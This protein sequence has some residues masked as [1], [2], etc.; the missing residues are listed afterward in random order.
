MKAESERIELN[1]VEKLKDVFLSLSTFILHSS[2]S[3]P[4]AFILIYVLLFFHH[5]S[6]LCLK[7][8]ID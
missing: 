3:S 5:D 1:F 7:T 4:G 8:A 2:S 6:N